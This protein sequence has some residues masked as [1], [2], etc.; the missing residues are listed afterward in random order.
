[1]LPVRYELNAYVFYLEEICF[2]K[3][4]DNIVFRA[5]TLKAVKKENY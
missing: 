2:L 5:Y 3:G 1:M 4:N